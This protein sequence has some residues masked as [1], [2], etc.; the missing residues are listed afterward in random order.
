MDHL[1][2]AAQLYALVA[3]ARRVSD[4]A[5]VV[6]ADALS[7]RERGYLGFA[8]SFE[9]GFV[10]QGRDE[11]RTLDGT[12]ECAWRVASML[13]PAELTMVSESALAAYYKGDRD[14]DADS[15]G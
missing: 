7:D 12:L 2:I 13:P 1:E 14:G 4:L 6:G 10:H 3:Q 8:D 15:T 9:T 5:E 11:L